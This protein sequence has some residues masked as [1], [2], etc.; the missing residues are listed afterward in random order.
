M[1]T[2][3]LKFLSV[4]G[5]LLIVAACNDSSNKIQEPE[6]V[7][8]QAT[9]TINDKLLNSMRDISNQHE[10]QIEETGKDALQQLS[11]SDRQSLIDLTID[12]S[13]KPVEED[14]KKMVDLLED[15]NGV[16]E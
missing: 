4:C 13:S 12:E 16:S 2:K 3:D 5:V 1:K 11:E 8:I 14:A 7:D 6:P 9:E 15:I 10:N